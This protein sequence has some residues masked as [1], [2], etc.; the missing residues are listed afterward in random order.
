[1]KSTIEENQ[2][3]I[4]QS[5]EKLIRM[6]KSIQKDLITISNEWKESNKPKKGHHMRV[7]YPSG[8]FE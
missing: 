3:R 8:D 2:E 7:K 1:M 5:I 6:T 4:S